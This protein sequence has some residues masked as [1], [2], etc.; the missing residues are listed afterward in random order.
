VTC[1]VAAGIADAQDDVGA[2]RFVRSDMCDASI[3]AGQFI[4]CTFADMRLATDIFDHCIS[5]VA[6]LKGGSTMSFF[7][8]RQLPGRPLRS[9]SPR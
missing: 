1:E 6:V 4:E 2:V 3:D 7:E 5:K 9:T 8:G